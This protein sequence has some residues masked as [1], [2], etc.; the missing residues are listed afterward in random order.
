MYCH[1]KILYY[2]EINTQIQ[3]AKENPKNQKATLRRLR[4]PRKN[5]DILNRMWKHLLKN[6]NYT[7]K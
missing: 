2:T 5:L 7:I 3:R 4:A 6:L 1:Y